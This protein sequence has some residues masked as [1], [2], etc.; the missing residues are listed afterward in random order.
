MIATYNEPT[1]RPTGAVLRH[2]GGYFKVNARAKV[3][4]ENGF[5]LFDL[6]ITLAIL[7]MVFTFAVPGM[8]SAV[9]KRNATSVAENIYSQ[10]QMARSESIARSQPVFMNLSAGSNW[11]LG[12]STDQAC[13]PTDDDP[14]CTLPDTD[15]NNAI[16]HRVTVNDHPD[17][18]VA[19]TANQITFMP[20]RGTAT[21]ATIN[22][23]SAGSVGYV[24][25]VNV[26]LLGQVSLCSSD[27][28]PSKYV[29]LYRACN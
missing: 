20:Q 3:N 26:G 5:T 29:R 12:F 1:K 7:A 18:S 10:I 2:P 6:M 9:E 14:A 22:I 21:A 4:K 13:D 24:M 16:S 15:G 27:T 23:T 11:A 19:T 8:T 17:I 25:T 28:D